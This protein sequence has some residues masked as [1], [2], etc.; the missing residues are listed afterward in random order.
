MTMFNEPDAVVED[1]GERLILT[2]PPK[3]VVIDFTIV[4]GMDTSATDI[5]R[6][7]SEVCRIH[8]CRLFFSGLSA[9]LRSMLVYAKLG[10]SY[11]RKTLLFAPDLESALAKAEDGLIKR[12]SHLGEKDESESHSLLERRSESAED[13]FLHALQK[14]DEQVGEVVSVNLPSI[15]FIAAQ[16]C[17]SDELFLRLLSTALILSMTFLVSP[18]T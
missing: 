17:S 11:E 18:N 3:Y 10:P 6:E 14:I 8:R 9:N 5:L 4:T 1:N 13:G 12:A 2:P 16:L 7:I 15:P